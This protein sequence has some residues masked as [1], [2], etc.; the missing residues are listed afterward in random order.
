MSYR[1]EL[2]D[3]STHVFGA[4]LHHPKIDEHIII[5]PEIRVDGSAGN[6]FT[7]HLVKGNTVGK[8]M[9][10]WQYKTL[11]AKRFYAGDIID[12]G[13]NFPSIIRF[14]E[15]LINGYGFFL[16]EV[17]T[18]DGERQPRR[19]LIN[20]YSTFPDKTVVIG[21]VSKYEVEVTIVPTPDGD[22]VC[23]NDYEV[24]IA[25]SNLKRLHPGSGIVTN[26]EM[27]SIT[28]LDNSFATTMSAEYF[29]EKPV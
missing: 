28:K 12:E 8:G 23:R 17:G 3:S 11:G 9:K 25:L 2:K 15:N 16:E 29:K 19:H 5:E 1:A 14:G 4:Y 18:I 22:F 24:E 26:K 7:F 27:W 6:G 20:A 13:D 10:V 21:H